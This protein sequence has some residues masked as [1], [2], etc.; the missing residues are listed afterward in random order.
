MNTLTYNSK[1]HIDSCGLADP[2]L[3]RL[4]A[5]RTPNWRIGHHIRKLPTEYGEF[6]IGNIQEI[7][8]KNLQ[9]MF[10]DI[11]LVTT[12][13][14]FKVER[15]GAIWRLLLNSYPNQ[16]LSNYVDPNVWIPLTNSVDQIHLSDW[17]SEIK[18]E[19]FNGNLEYVAGIPIETSIIWLKLDSAHSYEI[20]I[21]GENIYTYPKQSDCDL[22]I[23]L[24]LPKEQH[25]KSL[26]FY[27]TDVTN[28]SHRGYNHL[29]FLRLDTQILNEID[30]ESNCI[31][32][33]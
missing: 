12:G 28:Y 24:L 2:Y 26:Q 15:L 27:E 22:G 10:N 31:V 9:S 7:P 8:D 21:N 32:N 20:S 23:I 5:I 3:S 33:I 11:T 29:D 16:D 4:P 19:N 6:K 30:F 14:L 17:K 25:I 1:T 18:N 13:N